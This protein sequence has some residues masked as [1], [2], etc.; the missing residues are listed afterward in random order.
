[1][2]SMTLHGVGMFTSCQY[3][4]KTKNKGGNTLIMTVHFM[5]SLA[6]QRGKW[7]HSEFS[8]ISPILLPQCPPLSLHFG[9]S[10]N[11]SQ[12][13]WQKIFIRLLSLAFRY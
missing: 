7:I 2:L 11:R 4:P 10:G 6:Y 5:Q 13:Q 8:F 3:A 9:I 12:V 1:M